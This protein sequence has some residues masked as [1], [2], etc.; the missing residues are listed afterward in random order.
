MIDFFK[1]YTYEIKVLVK[2]KKMSL[3]TFF[4]IKNCFFNLI[5]KNKTVFQ[6]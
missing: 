3:S 6:K 2:V 1:A 4:W 5:F